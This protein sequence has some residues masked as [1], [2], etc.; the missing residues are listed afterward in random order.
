MD[1]N[2]HAVFDGR[3]EPGRSLFSRL[4]DSR[5]R[6][7]FCVQELNRVHFPEHAYTLQD[8]DFVPNRRKRAREPVKTYNTRPSTA[9]LTPPQEDEGSKGSR[10]SGSTEDESDTCKGPPYPFDEDEV[11]VRSESM[12]SRKALA[13]LDITYPCVNLP[14]AASS[15]AT[16]ILAASAA[17][18]PSIQQPH[19][20]PASM[21]KSSSSGEPM[22]M[23]V[24]VYKKQRRYESHSFLAHLS[25]LQRNCSLE[26]SF[27]AACKSM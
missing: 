27:Q 6:D 11:E 14:Q 18:K 4:R 20:A 24:L 3:A 23:D 9:P 13:V 25:H 5:R 12:L 10:S 21:C 15:L 8:T 26:T 22:A 16:F 17:C 2:H 1:S 7:H 19:S